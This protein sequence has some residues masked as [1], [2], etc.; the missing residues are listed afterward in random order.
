MTRKVSG[1][2]K[3]G[4]KEKKTKDT[5]HLEAPG[6]REEVAAAVEQELFECLQAS[7]HRRSTTQLKNSHDSSQRTE[8]PTTKPA[9]ANFEHRADSATPAFTLD[10]NKSYSD[11]S[12]AESKSASDDVY[13]QLCLPSHNEDGQGDQHLPPKENDSGDVFVQ[14]CWSANVQDGDKMEKDRKIFLEK[15]K[16]SQLPIEKRPLKQSG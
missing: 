5:F 3:R 9:L 10:F 14:Y 4:N 15:Y 7:R 12:A 1:E 8:F 6:I 16:H 13:L 11:M 2:Q